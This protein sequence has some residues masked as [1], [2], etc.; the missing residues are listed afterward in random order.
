MRSLPNIINKTAFLIAVVVLSSATTGHSQK[1]RDALLKDVMQTF[2]ASEK[3][4]LAGE[5]MYSYNEVVSFYQLG[6]YKTA[7]RKTQNVKHLIQSI[8]K[9]PE[10]GLNPIDYH[11]SVLEKLNVTVRTVEQD[12]AFDILLTD[13]FLT[14]A[15]HLLSGKT[16]PYILYPGEWEVTRRNSDLKLLLQDALRE[17]SV[18]ESLDELKPAYAGY[19][20]LKKALSFYRSIQA[21]GGWNTIPDGKTLEPGDRDERISAIR[22][23]LS[24][25]GQLPIP[26]GGDSSSYDSI[27]LKSVID[28][29][30][31][32]GLKDD[33]VIGKFTQQALNLTVWDYI[34][35]IL[36]NLERYRWLPQ[37]LG[38]TYVMINVA[39]Y[40][41]EVW[42]KDSVVLSMKIIVGRPERRTPILSSSL[43]YLILN[44]T[45]TVPPT[46]FKEDVLPA[47]KKDIS[48]LKHHHLRVFRYDGTE[49]D[50]TTLKWSSFSERNFPYTIRQDPGEQNS[51]GLIKFHFPNHHSIFL[52]D[53]NYPYLFST[54]YRALSSGCIRL[55]KPFALAKFALGEDRLIEKMEERIASGETE[56][57]VIRNPVPIHIFYF[58]AFADAQGRLQH[59]SDIYNW[60]ETGWRHLNSYSTEW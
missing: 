5:E 14:F 1:T 35:C 7:W 56:T 53:T 26:V 51:L 12:I 32:H 34:K 6:H 43:K 38:N 22:K 28:F 39:G 27:L 16:D 20:N 2:A 24:I 55:E 25:S 45:W 3:K 30:R 59:R 18:M 17:Q 33:G 11:Q 49:V 57:M 52:H 58:T 10:E 19:R 23:R 8:R 40:T 15:R 50:P 54:Y 13:A 42:S 60:D 37:Q 48:Y 21:A 36:I 4:Q 44:P 29:Q 31:Q 47:V 46:I 9:A 41:L